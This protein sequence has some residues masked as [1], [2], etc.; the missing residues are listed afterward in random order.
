MSNNALVEFRGK[1]ATVEFDYEHD[2]SVGIFNNIIWW[3]VDSKLP[4][5]ET[6]SEAEQDAIYKTLLA[7]LH[8]YESAD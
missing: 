4:D 1:M 2:P 5:A 7:S 3:F 8:D 6:L